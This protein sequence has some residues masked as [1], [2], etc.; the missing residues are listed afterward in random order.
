MKALLIT[1]LVAVFFVVAMAFGARND[2]V[3]TLN[4]FIARGEFSLPMV[5]A[6]TFFSGFV[7]S[8]LITMA[9]MLGQRFKLGRIT[10]R[11]QQLEKRIAELESNDTNA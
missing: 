3:I 11:N 7:I 1:A 5:L 9:L 6:A 4:Y 2:Q 8:W 10:A